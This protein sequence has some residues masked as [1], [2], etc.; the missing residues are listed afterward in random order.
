MRSAAGYSGEVIRLLPDGTKL[1]RLSIASSMVDGYYW[2]QV[3]TGTGIVGYVARSYLIDVNGNPATGVEVTKATVVVTSPELTVGDKNTTDKT[4][5][6]EPNVTVKEI[7]AKYSNAVIKDASGNKVTD[8]SKKIGTGYTIT[9]S[10]QTFAAVKLGDING[11]GDISPLDYVKI[12]N[13]I[14][15]TTTLSGC[16]KS[17]ADT[18]GDKDITPLDYVKVKNRI[19]KVSSISL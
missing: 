18:N 14:M 7:L 5:K 12:K 1:L 8:N 6:M 3:I 15:K 19:M 2:D 16:Y 9:I 13:H 11:D 10:D 4:I 17:A